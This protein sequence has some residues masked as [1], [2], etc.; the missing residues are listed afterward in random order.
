MG[1][2][3]AENILFDFALYLTLAVPFGI[4]VASADIQTALNQIF[5]PWPTVASV[6]QAVPK[7]GS[8]DIACQAQAGI[9]QATAFIAVPFLWIGAIILSGLQRLNAFGTVSIQLTTGPT[10][11]LT[12]IPGAGFI[13]FGLIVLVAFELFRM[14]RGSPSGT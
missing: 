8:T 2:I 14:F 1:R 5:G 13:V 6:T 10:G 7:C 3:S 11:S 12:T 4:A 9:A